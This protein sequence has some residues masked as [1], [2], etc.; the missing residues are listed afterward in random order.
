MRRKVGCAPAKL[1]CMKCNWEAGGVGEDQEQVVAELIRDQ[2]GRRD[3]LAF[4][5]PVRPSCLQG[6]VHDVHPVEL[7]D[8]LGG[9]GQLD[10]ARG[11]GKIDP[12]GRRVEVQHLDK[13][14]ADSG[15]PL[16]RRRVEDAPG[17]FFDFDRVVTVLDGHGRDS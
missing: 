9:V 16:A 13:Q 6:D 1:G 11:A 17:A 4:A 15:R 14:R 12:A 3:H 7:R 5:H 8:A 2:L 10:G